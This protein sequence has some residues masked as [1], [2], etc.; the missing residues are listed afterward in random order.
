MRLGIVGPAHGVRGE[1]VIHPDADLADQL[2]PGLVCRTGGV[3]GDEGGGG[4]LEVAAVR[5]HKERTLVRF[6]GVEDRATAESLRGVVLEIDRADVEADEGTLWV[7]DLLGAEV[8]TEGG[9]PVGV[10]QRVDDGP[11]HDWLV[12]ARSGGDEVMLPLAEELV[13]VDPDTARVT[14]RP[15]PGLLDDDWA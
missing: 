11:A 1:V 9:E 10:V 8:T 2:V 3:R 13:D 7:A 5:E 12:V 15:L 4:T 6:A 14:V